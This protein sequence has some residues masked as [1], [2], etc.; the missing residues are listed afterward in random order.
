MDKCPAMNV[1]SNHTY[2]IRSPFDF[3]MKY[4]RDK[5]EW[6]ISQNGELEKS[7][8]I[9]PKDKMPYIQLSVFYLFWCNKKCDVTLW[10]HDPPMWTQSGYKDW[11]IASGMIPIG[12]YTRNTS[13]GF[14]L[15]SGGSFVKINR[16]DVI[17]S[18]T[19]VSNS[20]VYL[21]KKN[22][23]NRIFIKNIENNEKK[24]SCPMKWSFELFKKWF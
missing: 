9:L 18:I 17:S 4:D 16:G 22:P 13:I 14:G 3:N 1:Y 10:Q 2:L 5:G 24:F 6:D 8:I 15:K 12:E 21:Q 7:L 11:Y 19:F 20:K 23:K